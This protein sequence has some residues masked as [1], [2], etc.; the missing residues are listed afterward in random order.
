MEKMLPEETKKVKDKKMMYG[1]LLNSLIDE[2]DHIQNLNSKRHK[3]NSISFINDMSNA[4]IKFQVSLQRDIIGYID[5]LK[6]DSF[7]NGN[8]QI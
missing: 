1:S 3:E 4:I 8:N 6:D 7:I 2:Y 5:T